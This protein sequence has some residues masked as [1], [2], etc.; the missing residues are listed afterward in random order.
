MHACCGQMPRRPCPHRAS[1]PR[2]RAQPPRR[3]RI[4]R[5]RDQRPCASHRH[6]RARAGTPRMTT[7]NSRR[8]LP[9]V[10]AMPDASRETSTW[11]AQPHPQPPWHRKRVA[12]SQER[13]TRCANCRKAARRAARSPRRFVHVPRTPPPRTADGYRDSHTRTAHPHAPATPRAPRKARRPHATLASPSLVP[14]YT[15][16]RPRK[17]TLF[18]GKFPEDA[19]RTGE[20]GTKQ[21]ARSLTMKPAHGCSAHGPGGF[22]IEP[23][24]SRHQKK[25]SKKRRSVW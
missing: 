14:C 24:R 3:T 17:C 4:P 8:C 22:R 7:D 10:R 15:L 1:H 25:P 23:A 13:P 21:P 19:L 2:I 11:R 18:Q 9:C 5:K 16:A 12:H 6:R 20:E